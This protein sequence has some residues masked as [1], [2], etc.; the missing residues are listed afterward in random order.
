MLTLNFDGI[1]EKPILFGGNSGKS[2]QNRKIVVALSYFGHGILDLS[3]NLKVLISFKFYTNKITN[4]LEYWNAH[5]KFFKSISWDIKLLSFQSAYNLF[6]V[7]RV[8]FPSNCTFI[9]TI[10]NLL[11]TSIK[12]LNIFTKESILSKK[13]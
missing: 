10:L 5:K 2:L 11:L 4:R 8:F 3:K 12:K 1:L 9:K 13:L 7:Y 6:T